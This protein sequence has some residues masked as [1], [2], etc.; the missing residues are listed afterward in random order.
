MMCLSCHSTGG[1]AD[2]KIPIIASHPEGKLITNV[3][4]DTSGRADYFPLFDKTTGQLITVG[5][6]SCPSCHNAHKWS[7]E[8]DLAGRGAKQEGSAEN[9]FLRVQS[10]DLPCMDCH[11]PDGLFKYL[12]FHDPGKRTIKEE[13]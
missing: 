11:G 8:T 1:A 13:E 6:I 9:S 2:N 4:R 10:S 7:P 12:Y 5:N 3:G